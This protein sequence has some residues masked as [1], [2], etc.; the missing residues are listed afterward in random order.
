[1]SYFPQKEELSSKKRYQDA[2]RVLLDYAKDVREAVIA[3]VQ[4]NHFSEAR[5]IVSQFHRFPGKNLVKQIGQITLYARTELMV[6]IIYP[7]ALESQAQIL[8][9]IDEMKQQLRKQVQ[10]LRELRI[11]KVEEPG[12]WYHC[13]L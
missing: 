1:M 7:G 6:D 10:R 3:L 11:K 8:E 4:G 5:R 9:D 2:S 12:A 13:S